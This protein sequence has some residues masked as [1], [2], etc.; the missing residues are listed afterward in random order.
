MQ[1]QRTAGVVLAGGVAS[2]MAGTPKHLFR[3]A[4][5][6]TLVERGVSLLIASGVSPVYV[7]V[8]A[9]G[10][11]VPPG[12]SE[13][14]RLMEDLWPGVGPLG[15]IAT[16]LALLPDSLGRLLVIPSD[17]P[18][19]RLAQLR[20]IL[21]MSQRELDRITVAVS[22]SG[23]HPLCCAIPMRGN[24]RIISAVL[25]GHLSVRRLWRDLDAVPV[26]VPDGGSFLNV[27]SPTDVA[28]H[29]GLSL[30]A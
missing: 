10:S 18:R 22:C 14:T 1:I 21:A 7:S 24:R 29:A 8:R 27:N 28:E 12:C 26:Q 3:T 30:T 15:G 2:R 17:L 13:P 11:P 19:L 16:T 5:G 9:G 20:P 4:G 25:G 23:I 6:E